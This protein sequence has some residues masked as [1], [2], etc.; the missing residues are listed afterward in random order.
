VEMMGR[1]SFVRGNSMRLARRSCCCMVITPSACIVLHLQNRSQGRRRYAAGAGTGTV[2]VV[3]LAAV[4]PLIAPR[5][6][7][8]QG[9]CRCSQD[10]VVDDAAAGSNRGA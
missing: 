8:R 9:L 2:V 3:V 6:V 4:K 10:L 7:Q 1:Y 5:H